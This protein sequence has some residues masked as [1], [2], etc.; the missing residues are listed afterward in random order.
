MLRKLRELG[1]V[2]I[3][4]KMQRRL[5]RTLRHAEH[6]RET[7]EQ[8]LARL[9]S[10]NADSDFSRRYLSGVSS[11]SQFRKRF[12]ISDDEMFVPFIERVKAG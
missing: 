7:Q 3:R 4:W 9:L 2:G 10:L 11:A 5:Q 12:S 8:T 1:V 6:C